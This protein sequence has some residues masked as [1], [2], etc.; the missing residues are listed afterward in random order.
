MRHTLAS[1][2]PR[3]RG[4]WVHDLGIEG[5]NENS[6]ARETFNLLSFCAPRRSVA[7]HLSCPLALSR[8]S[9]G[10]SPSQLGLLHSSGS[11]CGTLGLSDS[12]RVS[13]P[14]HD[15]AR[16]KP[17]F[18][19]LCPPWWHQAGCLRQVVKVP[20]CK[21]QDLGK[22][23]VT[24]GGLKPG[25]GSRP[26]RPTEASGLSLGQAPG[27]PGAARPLMAILGVQ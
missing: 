22:L 18:P 16:A 10:S 6:P 26:Q 5:I 11:L 27:A 3:E 20:W 4:G 2:G 9:G 17:E 15:E 23:G 19:H 21:G 12:P 1:F 7:P 14:L 8:P 25:Q 13:D 24:L